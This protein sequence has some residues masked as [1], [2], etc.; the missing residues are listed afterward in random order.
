MKKKLII[1]ESQYKRLF[2]EQKTYEKPIEVELESGE[3]KTFKWDSKEYQDWYYNEGKSYK[4]S[5]SKQKYVM[6]YSKIYRNWN[7]MTY[8]QRLLVLKKRKGISEPMFLTKD[9]FDTHTMID[10]AAIVT[11]FIPVVGP[12]ISVGLEGLNTALYIQE[13]D[14]FG[15]TLSGIFTLVPGGHLVWR[16]LKNAGILKGLN[17][18]VKTLS[19]VDKTTITDELILSELTKNIGEKGVKNNSNLIK[20]YFKI[21]KEGGESIII[22]K[23]KNLNKLVKV[24]PYHWKSFT[25][26]ETL[27][28]TFLKNN[29]DDLEKA[30]LAYLKSLPMQY[31]QAFVGIGIYVAMMKG[32]DALVTLPYTEKLMMDAVLYY[33]SITGG[34]SGVVWNEGYDWV[35]TKEIFGSDG[36]LKDNSLLKKAWD[37]GWRPYDKNDLNKEPNQPPEEF[38]T[39]TYKKKEE[40]REVERRNKIL[41]TIKKKGE[42][43]IGVNVDDKGIKKIKM[44]LDLKNKDKTVEIPFEI[45]DKYFDTTNDINFDEPIE[46]NNNKLKGDIKSF[47]NVDS[48][49][50]TPQDSLR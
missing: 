31:T 43:L 21:I 4:W 18:T 17:K 30:Y 50:S 49:L 46:M 12:F 39:D 25:K 7:T 15:A 3:I 19:T 45:F 13:G 6:D 22:D 24:T 5:P 2:I 27:F 20:E 26:N 9:I 47:N 42:E 44:K 16:G 40:M 33:R 35:T 10:I 37:S 41:T 28:N 36:S 1:T 14:K 48:L 11:A 38:Q 32:M 8:D 29:G 34:V 23:G